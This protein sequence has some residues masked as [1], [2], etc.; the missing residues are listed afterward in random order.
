[1]INE[2]AENTL[3][4]MELQRKIKELEKRMDTVYKIVGICIYKDDEEDDD[5]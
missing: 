3:D 2:T 5:E 4:I 1:M